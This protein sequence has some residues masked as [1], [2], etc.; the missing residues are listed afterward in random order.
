MLLSYYIINYAIQASLYY[1]ISYFPPYKFLHAPVMASAYS[2]SP[3]LLYSSWFMFLISTRCTLLALAQFLT[4]L[5]N[6]LSIFWKRIDRA[7]TTEE[8]RTTNRARIKTCLR[9]KT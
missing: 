6:P 8:T 4:I 5:C 1:Y 2:V 7:V 3:P 9:K